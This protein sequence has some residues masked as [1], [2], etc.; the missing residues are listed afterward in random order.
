MAQDHAAKIQNEMLFTTWN[1]SCK[2][3][4]LTDDGDLRECRRIANHDEKHA[5][6][7]GASFREW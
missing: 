1:E 6:G 5:S 3:P 7:F 4:A 2:D